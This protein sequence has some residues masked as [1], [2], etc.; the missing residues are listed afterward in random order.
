[1]ITSRIGNERQFE[2]EWQNGDRTLQHIYNIFLSERRD[3]YFQEKERRKNGEENDDEDDDYDSQ[4]ELEQIRY[5]KTTVLPSISRDR[6]TPILDA[7]D[8]FK[9]RR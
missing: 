3:I 9:K 6:S 5:S 1:M 2:I 8:F 7:S 4:E